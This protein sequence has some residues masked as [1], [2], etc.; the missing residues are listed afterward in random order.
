MRFTL[1]TVLHRV[2][3]GTSGDLAGREALRD[4]CSSIVLKLLGRSLV[5]TADILTVTASQ[6]VSGELTALA[7]RVDDPEASPKT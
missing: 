6:Q 4:A 5:V 7:G 2:V 3:T 1:C